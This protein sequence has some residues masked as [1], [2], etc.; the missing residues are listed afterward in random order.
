MSA[1]S[2]RVSKKLWRVEVEW[3][4]SILMARG[5]WFPAS[6]V[7]RRRKNDRCYSVGFVL[8]DDKRGIVLANSVHGGE[9]CG[10][11]SIPRKAIVKRWRIR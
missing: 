9:T 3:R 10:T 5:E 7:Q 11:I 2:K 4:D 8:A 6:E 1:T